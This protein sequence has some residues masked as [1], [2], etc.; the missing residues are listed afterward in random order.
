MTY[1]N[2]CPG[3]QSIRNPV[4]ENIPCPQCGRDVEIWTDEKK[5]ICPGCKTAVFRERKMSCIDW[6]PYAKECVGPEVYER[7]KPAEKKRQC[8]G[9]AP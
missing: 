5:G 1:D 6:C 4:P 9:Y 8:G 3:S 2:H 7:L